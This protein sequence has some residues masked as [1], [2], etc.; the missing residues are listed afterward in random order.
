MNKKIKSIRKRFTNF[1][2]EFVDIDNSSDTE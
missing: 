1:I 2:E